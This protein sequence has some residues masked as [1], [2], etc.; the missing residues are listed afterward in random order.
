MTRVS[1]HTY[2]R[3]TH[4]HCL[5][6]NISQEAKRPMHIGNT[7]V[8]FAAK[9]PLFAPRLAL[10]NSC[11]LVVASKHD[12]KHY[13]ER[14]PRYIPPSQPA[15]SVVSCHISACIR[16][17]RCFSRFHRSLSGW[18][19]SHCYQFTFWYW[20]QGGCSCSTNKS[21][22]TGNSETLTLTH[23]H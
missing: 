15:L 19:L 7:N 17:V 1:F 20:V 9:N 3:F 12:L 13:H 18:T 23:Q 14:Q 11:G 6:N 22:L 5:S 10:A 2:A 8:Y 16:K 4:W 21:T